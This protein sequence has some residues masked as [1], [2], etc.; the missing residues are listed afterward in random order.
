MDTAV[1]RHLISSWQEYLLAERGLSNT[2][3]SAYREDLFNF[4]AFEEEL[5]KSGASS[6][7]L[8][9]PEIFLYM[10]WLNSQGNCSKTVARRLSSMRSFFS[11]AL[12]EGLLANN[13]VQSF[14]NPKLPQHLP[15][16][17]DREGMA[18]IL[19]APRADNKCGV[20]DKCILELLYAS[21]IR[22]S[23]LCGLKIDNIDF[24]TGLI[25]VFGKGK[26][27]R[28]VPIHQ[29]MQDMLHDYVAKW[30][31]LFSPVCRNAFTNRSGKS[32]TRQYIWKMIRKYALQAG[33]VQPVSPHTFRHSF[34]THLLEGGADL[35]AVQVLLGHADIAATELY[36]HIQPERLYR[37]HQQYHPRNNPEK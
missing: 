16:V 8:D 7:K 11:F 22:V 26:K 34:A 17:L 28:I 5:A 15:Y 19:D 18:K 2:T 29:L 36:T 23:E 10:A 4:I 13:P 20:R 1:L 32:L 35:R 21:G 9:E 30:R 25:R 33:I 12:E 14:E 37:L 31:P 24:Q 27:E 6:M 3:A